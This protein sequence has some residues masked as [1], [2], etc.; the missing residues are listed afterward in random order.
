MPAP[1]EAVQQ[2]APVVVEAPT[3]VKPAFKRARVKGTWTQYFGA[4][5]FD[6]I[7]GHSYDLPHDLFEYLRQHGN[8]YDTMA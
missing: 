7:D 5:R 3:I 4:Q 1:A 8:I 2:E 6:F